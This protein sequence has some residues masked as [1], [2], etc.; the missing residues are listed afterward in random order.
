MRAR[1]DGVGHG[2]GHFQLLRALF[3]I[4]EPGRNATGRAEDFAGIKH[5]KVLTATAVDEQIEFPY[6]W[7][8]LRLR[9][10]RLT[11]RSKPAAAIS[12]PWRDH[13]GAWRI[14]AA[15]ET[16]AMRIFV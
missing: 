7:A 10:L 11:C 15:N 2:G 3:V 1:F 13:R 4:V 9:F 5:G 8:S 14:V 6:F 12:H 16:L